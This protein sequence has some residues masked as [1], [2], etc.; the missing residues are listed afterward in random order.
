MTD[1]VSYSVM[2]SLYVNYLRA[3]LFKEDPPS[4]Y[5]VGS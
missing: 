1:S 3:I 4:T 5:T 2:D